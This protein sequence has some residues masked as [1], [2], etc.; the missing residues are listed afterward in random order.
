MPEVFTAHTDKGTLG[1]LEYRFAGCCGATGIFYHLR[2]LHLQL[3]DCPG[4][5]QI[6]GVEHCSTMGRTCA[7]ENTCADILF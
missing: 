3:V 4:N 7:D 6:T 1:R 5:K 2:T